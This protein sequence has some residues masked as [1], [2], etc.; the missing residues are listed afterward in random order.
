MKIFSAN[1]FLPAIKVGTAFAVTLLPF[2]TRT[3]ISCVAA[4]KTEQ[5]RAEKESIKSVLKLFA[6]H[7]LHIL[8]V[9]ILGAQNLAQD[10]K[11]G[12]ELH[13]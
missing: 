5:D 13:S 8:L 1:V 6:S 10:F 4:G 7:Q 12:L 2:R 9:R 11:K 3:R